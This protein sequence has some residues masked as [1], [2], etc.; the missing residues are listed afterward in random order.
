MIRLNLR[1]AILALAAAFAVSG[2]TLA[3]TGAPAV[4]AVRTA[5]AS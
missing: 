4:A 2:A 5:A 3:A 1:F